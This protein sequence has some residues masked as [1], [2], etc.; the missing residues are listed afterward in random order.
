MSGQAAACT[1]EEVRSK[2]KSV[3]CNTQCKAPGGGGSGDSLKS[4]KTTSNK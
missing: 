2:I 3:E 1:R 4:M